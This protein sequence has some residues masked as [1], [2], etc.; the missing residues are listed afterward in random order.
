MSETPNT[1]KS[2][3][4]FLLARYDKLANCKHES[5]YSQCP[6]EPNLIKET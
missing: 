2:L 6:T 5:I 1:I 4:G 3:Q